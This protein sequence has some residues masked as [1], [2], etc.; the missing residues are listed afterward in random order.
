MWTAAQRERYKDDGRRY[1]RDLTDAEWALLAPLFAGYASLTVDLREMVNACLYLQKTGCQWR[2]LPKEFGP[3]QTVRSWHDRFRADG[4]W[5]DAAALLTRGVRRRRGHAT[6]PRTAILDSQSVVSGPQRG[7]RGVDGNKRI[8]GIKR[9]VLTCSLGFVLAVLVTAANL[10]DTAAAAI[11]LDRAAADGW[12]PAG[13]RLG[14]AAPQGRRHLRRRPHGRRRRAAC[15]GA[16]PGPA[17][18]LARARCE[19][20]HAAARFTPLPLRWRI[21]ATFGTQTNRYR[22]LTRTLEQSPTP[23]EDA[24]AIANCHRVLRTYTRNT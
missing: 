19:R 7:E 14:A 24:V 1:P 10:H 16:C 13:R 12:A 15:P 5:T 9:H 17:G 8:K 23:A 11:L 4:V 22:R 6:E 3:W 21:E 20:L 18:H 2:F